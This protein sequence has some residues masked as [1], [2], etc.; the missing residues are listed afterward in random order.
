MVVVA[1]RR[2]MGVWSAGDVV[3]V[4]DGRKASAV[5][6]ALATTKTSRAVLIGRGSLSVREAVAAI[7]CC[8][9]GCT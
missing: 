4:E 7:V 8:F 2:E 3:L 6:K 1:E 9:G 5:D